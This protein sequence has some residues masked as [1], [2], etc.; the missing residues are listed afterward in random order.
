[1]C[2]WA[3]VDRPGKKDRIFRKAGWTTRV[4]GMDGAIHDLFCHEVFSHEAFCHETFC[5]EVFCR[6]AIYSDS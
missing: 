3:M 4:A 5:R 1:M 6:E 2:R